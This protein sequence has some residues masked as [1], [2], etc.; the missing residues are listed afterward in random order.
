MEEEEPSA[1]IVEE[2]AIELY[3]SISL[4]NFRCSDGN[5]MSRS[6]SSHL[7]HPKSARTQPAR[8]DNKIFVTNLDGD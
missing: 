5:K 6:S 1:E 3:K 7:D 2:T 4:K 8:N